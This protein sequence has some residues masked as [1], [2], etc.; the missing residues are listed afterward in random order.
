MEPGMAPGMAPDMGEG[1]LQPASPAA[2]VRARCTARAVREALTAR[3]G[4]PS[5]AALCSC[6]APLVGSAASWP[7]VGVGVA[8]GVRGWN[9]EAVLRSKK[10]RLRK[11]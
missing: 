11:C 5:E 1:V 10:R 6:S 7:G 9:W 3:T 4:V 8:A 2:L